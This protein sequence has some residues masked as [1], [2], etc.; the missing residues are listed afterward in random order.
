MLIFMVGQ[1]TKE[2]MNHSLISVLF[3][4]IC[5][6]FYRIT[7]FNSL[8]LIQ[9]SLLDK[10]KPRLLLFCMKQYNFGTRMFIYMYIYLTIHIFMIYWALSKKFANINSRRPY[11]TEVSI[12][13][14][15][16]LQTRGHGQKMLS[17]LLKLKKKH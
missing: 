16:I 4:F 12:I 10:R 7:C 14:I 17:N 5:N 6:S 9:N 2:N 11:N 3:C 15:P 1:R 8:L 13:I